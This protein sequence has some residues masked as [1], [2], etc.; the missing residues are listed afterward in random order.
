M[1]VL[2]MIKFETIKKAKCGDS[3]ALKEI[4]Q[5][6]QKVIKTF[7]NDEDFVQTAL[8]KVYTCIKKFEI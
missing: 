1:E 4:L 3:K 6:Y 5:Y 2:K 7:S 8:I